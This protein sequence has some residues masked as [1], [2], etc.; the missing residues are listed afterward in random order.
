MKMK[1][2]IKKILVLIPFLISFIVMT[3]NHINVEKEKLL[4]MKQQ[5]SLYDGY[6]RFDPNENG[7]VILC[8]HRI[9]SNNLVTKQSQE[10]SESSQL[11]S[12]NVNEDVFYRQMQYLKDHN[13]KVI[14][15]DE[16]MEMLEKKRRINKKYVVITFDDI[17][18]TM[19][20]NAVPI[21]QK[22]NYPYTTFIIGN[23]TDQYVDGSYMA[24]WE[25]IKQVNSDELNTMG[26]HSFDSHYQEK[27]KP[28]LMKIS[29]KE[30]DEDTNKESEIFEKH[31]ITG[32]E[33]YAPPYGEMRN[34]LKKRLVE[35]H[36]M[37]AVFT[38]DN[39]IVTSIKQKESMPRIIVTEKSFN[40]L[41]RWFNGKK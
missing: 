34:E 3:Y 32:V 30:F 33:Y 37:R 22:F 17:D 27:K 23:K 18:V 41:K 4:K 9:S 1:K 20:D 36:G 39:D 8:Y 38:L 14:S 5:Q 25:Q 15:I 21:L 6:G 7:I 26:M 31:G 29:N 10:M 12:F 24:D 11:H 28:R 13:I 16:M 35:E 2:N 19:V 40:N